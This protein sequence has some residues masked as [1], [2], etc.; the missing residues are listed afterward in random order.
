[1]QG[2]F[3]LQQINKGSIIINQVVRARNCQY[4]NLK[5]R[6]TPKHTA[7]LLGKNN[8]Y[9]EPWVADYSD[10]ITTSLALYTVLKT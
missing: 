9:Y 5:N 6:H 10:L 4:R 7:L 3:V 1:M 2:E 8:I